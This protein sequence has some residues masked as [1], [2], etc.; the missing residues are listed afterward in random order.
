MSLIRKLKKKIKSFSK[1]KILS[2]KEDFKLELNFLFKKPQ[3]DVVY[4]I[5]D[6]FT[7]SCFKYEFNLVQL[8]AN[9]WKKQFKYQKPKFLFCE[10]AWEANNSQWVGAFSDKKSTKHSILS[11][12]ISYCNKENIKTVFWNKEDPPNFHHFVDVATKFDVIYTTEER[13]VEEYKKRAPKAHVSSMMFAAQPLIHNAVDA[14]KNELICF[15]GAWRGF[16]YP[17]RAKELEK[18]IDIISAN[19]KVIIYDRDYHKPHSKNRFP[20]KYKKIVSPPI[21]YEMLSNEYRNFKAMINV[22]SVSDSETMCARRIFEILSSRTILLTSYSPAVTKIFDKNVYMEGEADG[23]IKSFFSDSDLERSRKIQLNYRTVL[24]KHTYSRRADKI[25]NDLGFSDAVTASPKVQV[26]VGEHSLKLILE[27]LEQ[28]KRQ[29]YINKT[30]VYLGNDEEVK[31]IISAENAQ[32]SIQK[33]KTILST[34][35]MPGYMYGMNYLSDFILNLQ[36]K[37]DTALCKDSFFI[38]HVPSNSLYIRNPS[39]TFKTLNGTEKSVM[40]L[41][42]TGFTNQSYISVDPYNLLKVT[43]DDVNNGKLITECTLEEAKQ[44]VFV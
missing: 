2:W 34:E 26:I 22:N 44:I 38:Y 40:T 16:K 25:K 15:A 42:N 9:K 13:L 11:E 12:I 6:D 36:I 24:D 5:L 21:A 41:Q 27:L 18:M 17:E 37:K 31:R 35:F 3:D 1:R 10:S 39:S 29:S 4:C 33:D 28:F 20:E 19:D 8:S 23:G 30:F 43:E 14:N 7:Y 32:F